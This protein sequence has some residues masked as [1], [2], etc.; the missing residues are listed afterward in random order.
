MKAARKQYKFKAQ[1][2]PGMG[3]GAGVMFPCDAQKEF[4][5]GRKVP[6]QATL[7]SVAY[8]GPLMH[9]GMNSHTLGVLKSI[10]EQI[11]KGTGDTIDVVEWKDQQPRGTS[12]LRA[13]LRGARAFD[14]GFSICETQSCCL[15]GPFRP[16]FLRVPKWRNW[17]TRMVQVHVL[18]R[19]WGF[20]SLLRHQSLKSPGACCFLPPS[21]SR[22]QPCGHILPV[23]RRAKRA[24]DRWWLL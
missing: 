3:G 21:R 12:K 6:V 5:T 15:L 14:T 24:W 17:Q 4:G 10:R 23:I 7:D 16:S 13:A 19:V 2:I 9:C 1:A 8:R 22:E 18:A 20:E 11:G